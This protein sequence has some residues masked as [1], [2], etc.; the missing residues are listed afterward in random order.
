[1]GL[2]SNGRCLPVEAVGVSELRSTA[3]QKCEKGL[4]VPTGDN[5]SGKSLDARKEMWDNSI[6][7][8]AMMQQR[9]ARVNVSEESD[10]SGTD[11]IPSHRQ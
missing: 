7:R 3:A 1:V 4:G 11:S 10:W 6:R 8:G 5:R 2:R 9:S